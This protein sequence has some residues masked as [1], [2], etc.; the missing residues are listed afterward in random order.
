MALPGPRP[1]RTLE[2]FPG[3][4]HGFMRATETVATA[5]NAVA[6]AAE[7]LKSRLE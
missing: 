6:R 1:D 7:W 3:V 4:I 2:I 5:R